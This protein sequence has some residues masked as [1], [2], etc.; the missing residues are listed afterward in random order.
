[1]DEKNECAEVIPRELHDREYK[2][3]R[4]VIPVK[5]MQQHELDLLTW[6]LEESSVFCHS[7]VDTVI[8]VLESPNLSLDW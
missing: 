7:L 4:K 5:G 1:M 6:V 3:M 2:S 8:D